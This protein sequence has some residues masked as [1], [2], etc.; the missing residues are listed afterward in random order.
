MVNQDIRVIR[1]NGKYVDRG[2]YND[3]LVRFEKGDEGEAEEKRSVGGRWAGFI[4]Q[5]TVHPP[6][7]HYL[8]CSAESRETF[9]IFLFAIETRNQKPDIA[10]R[11]ARPLDRSTA[12]TVLPL[13]FFHT[14]LLIDH[15]NSKHRTVCKEDTDYSTSTSLAHLQDQHSDHSFL[16]FDPL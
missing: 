13:P 15:V 5:S 4:F 14:K 16:L 7:V 2:N 10:H 11:T 1:R 6:S 9:I 12:Q 8:L 3:C